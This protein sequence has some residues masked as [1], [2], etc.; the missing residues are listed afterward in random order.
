MSK[1]TIKTSDDIFFKEKIDFK[2]L[3]ESMYT[4][5]A[6][7]MAKAVD[8]D[9]AKTPI[10]DFFTGY[11]KYKE[12]EIKLNIANELLDSILVVSDWEHEGRFRPVKNT[13]KQDVYKVIC[14][15]NE[16]LKTPDKANYNLLG[17][18]NDR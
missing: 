7:D 2:N 8:I 4:Q 10:I 3:E 13:R 1:E 9:F 17:D 5:F 16:L 6:K 15:L 11:T 14:Q 12:L 18:N